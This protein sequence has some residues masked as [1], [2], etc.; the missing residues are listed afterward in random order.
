M[1]LRDY[2]HQHIKILSLPLIIILLGFPHVSET[3]YTP[4]LP[5][6]A[7]DLMT[8]PYWTEMS[9]SIY[10]VGFALGVAFW[11]FCSDK[12]GRRPALLAGLSI[13]TITCLLLG[14]CSSIETLLF[15]RF[16]QAFGASAGSVVTQTML[17]DV[18]EGK[19]RHQ[20]FAVVSGALAFTPAIGPWIGGYVAMLFG[21]QVN[22]YVLL[23][24]GALLLLY[25]IRHLPETRHTKQNSIISWSLITRMIRDKHLLRH[26]AFI[27]LCNGIVFGFYAEA[28]FLF[29]ELIGFTPPIYGSFGLILC[30]AGLGASF[31][32][33][34]LNEVMTPEHIIKQAAMI[35]VIGSLNLLIAAWIG[36]FNQ[37]VGIAGIIYI[38]IGI[39]LSFTGV[40][41]LI[42]NSLSLALKDYRDSLGVAGAYFGFVYYIGIACCMTAVSYLHNGTPYPMPLLFLFF[43]LLLYKLGHITCKSRKTTNVE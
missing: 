28:P 13:Y 24:T 22:F 30:I 21:W 2:M 33:H 9:L 43:S 5:L 42:S 20:I 6:I 18:Y 38:A 29:I 14:L 34:K 27:S 17:R 26:I 19:K 39:G 4:S 1:K 12:I 10:F 11:G 41:L 40:G 36:L 3:I 23:T 35:C 15:W 31:I 7:K 32:S 16:I 8:T 37:S 25:C